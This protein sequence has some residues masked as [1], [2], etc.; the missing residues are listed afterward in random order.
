MSDRCLIVAETGLNHNGSA[1]TAHRMI[2][3]IAEAGA[4]SAKFQCYRTSDFVRDRTLRYEGRSQVEMFERYELPDWVW[5]ELRDHCAEVGLMFF[6]TP[7][8]EERLEFLLELGVPMLKNGSDYL[9]HLPL[10]RA[11]ARTGL[12]TVLACGMAHEDEIAAAVEAF[13]GAGGE[14]L[15][16]LHCTSNYPAVA[17]DVHLRKMLTLRTRFSYPVGLSDHTGGA[18]AAVGAVAYGGM[19]VEKHFTLDRNQ[20]GP[21]HHFSADPF[22]LTMLVECVR[23]VEPMIG[24]WELGPTESEQAS[25]RY[26]VVERDGEWLR[27]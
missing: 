10:I 8:S 25:R 6:A 14:H 3:A 12:P 9:G 24:D 18:V 13:E 16:L 2:D 20:P 1:E 7:T 21:D 23:L 27:R 19:M 17:E 15:T 4:D 5:P 11:M 26:R 22:D